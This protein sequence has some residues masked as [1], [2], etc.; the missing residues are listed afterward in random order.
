MK[1]ANR[2][3]EVFDHNLNMMREKARG[4]EGVDFV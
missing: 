4:E 2:F 3:K 1:D